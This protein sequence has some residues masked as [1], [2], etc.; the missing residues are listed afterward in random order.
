MLSKKNLENACK[1]QYHG[2]D[3]SPIYKYILSPFAQFC[4]DAFTPLW[5][6]PNLVTFIGLCSSMLSV[7]CVLI[8][9]PTLGPNGPKWLSLLTGVCIFIYQTLDNMDG[10]QAR[11]TGS[12]SA[13]GMLFDHGCDAI[14]AGL[15]AIPIGSALGTGWTISVFFTLWCGFVPF[16]FQTWEEYYLGAM[17]LPPINGPTEGLL[18]AVGMCFI[19][20][21]KGSQIWTEVNSLHEFSTENFCLSS[22]AC[23]ILI[24]FSNEI[25]I[26][27]CFIFFLYHHLT[28]RQYFS[29][30]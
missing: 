14:N 2:S 24:Y 22:T 13:L 19:S 4:V 12:T 15:C 26:I 29:M 30:N 1:Y 18:I 8:Y 10:K 17:H 11:K 3:S 5:M 21:C 23:Y 28:R 16:Y 27:K 6:A 20:H 7:T 9:N 25:S